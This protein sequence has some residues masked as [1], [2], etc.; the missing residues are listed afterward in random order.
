M[1]KII[2]PATAA[3][4]LSFARRMPS[5]LHDASWPGLELI[6]LDSKNLEILLDGLAG[7]ISHCRE[8]G[9]DRMFNVHARTFPPAGCEPAAWLRQAARLSGGCYYAVRLGQ[10]W[11]GFLNLRGRERDGTGHIRAEY[12]AALPDPA[13][14]GRGLAVALMALLF[15]AAFAAGLD[16]ILIR[17]AAD[18]GKGRQSLAGLG[19]FPLPGSGPDDEGVEVL[20]YSIVPASLTDVRFRESRERLRTSWPPP[21]QK[22]AGCGEILLPAKD[23]TF[24]GNIWNHPSSSPD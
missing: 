17:I 15:P 3:T 6:R 1:Q 14:R 13:L 21:G 19:M 22:H 12:G 7:F 24:S 11:A 8:Q 9:W 23:E 4:G 10:D 2:I 16:S 20:S 18:S 5:R